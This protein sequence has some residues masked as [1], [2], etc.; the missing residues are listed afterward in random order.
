MESELELRPSNSR[1]NWVFWLSPSWTPLPF[2]VKYLNYSGCAW[3]GDCW[4]QLFI[5]RAA[6]YVLLSSFLCAG[7]Y[8]SSIPCVSL[9]R[10]ELSFRVTHSVLCHPYFFQKTWIVLTVN[11]R[12]D[13]RWGM[14]GRT[15]RGATLVVQWLRPHDPNAGG[16]GS[17]PHW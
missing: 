9:F 4:L 1:P 12:S 11:K 10:N 16:P 3:A 6:S 17:I 15:T 2:G 8:P 7:K 13:A 5:S 14:L